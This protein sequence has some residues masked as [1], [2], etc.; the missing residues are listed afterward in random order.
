MGLA[1]LVFWGLIFPLFLGS[2]WRGFRRG[3]R[4]L[5]DCGPHPTRWLFLFEAVFLVFMGFAFGVSTGANSKLFGI[6]AP[7]FGTTCAIFFVILAT[8]RLQIREGGIWQYWALLPWAKLASYSWSPD[9]TLLL[10]ARNPLPFLGAGRCPC[11]R[12]NG[13]MSRRRCRNV[14]PLIPIWRE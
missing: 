11:R 12:R 10:Q 13:M 6:G 1:I 8:G 14:S 7:V 9:S 3:G 4:V 5:L 2:W